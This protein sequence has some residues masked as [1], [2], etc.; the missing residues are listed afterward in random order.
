GHDGA[1]RS[2]RIET[3]SDSAPNA[4]DLMDELRA[5]REA[6]AIAEARA[7]EFEAERDSAA[8]AR[9]SLRTLAAHLIGERA[10]LAGQLTRI[11][12]RP[13]KPIKLA[14]TYQ[15]LRILS[16]ASGP[17]SEGLSGRLARSAE[18]R[19][20][21]RFDRFLSPPGAPAPRRR[22]FGPILESENDK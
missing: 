10:Y 3:V 6:Q 13:W 2:D 21:T 14:A 18:K 16:A 17:I 9:E 4:A 19:S 7:A 5:A 8:A 1:S 12:K 15:L 11:Y 22:T 20:P